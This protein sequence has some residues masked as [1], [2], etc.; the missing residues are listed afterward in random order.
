MI[1]NN[2]PQTP[3]D[4]FSYDHSADH[5]SLFFPENTGNTLDKVTHLETASP[6]TLPGRVLSHHPKAGLNPLVD[7]AGYLFS[8]LGKL[9]TLN[10]FCQLD[11][12]QTRLLQEL[13]IFQLTAKKHGYKPD[14][15]LACR[16][17]LSATFDDIVTHSGWGGQGQW[18]KYRLQNVLYPNLD[19]PNR[20]FAIIEYA[21]KEPALHIGL[22]ELAYLC[23]GMG[24]KGSY[25]KTEHNQYQL[26]LITNNLYKHIRAFRGNFG[27]LL[28]PALPKSFNRPEQAGKQSKLSLFYIFF[29]TI[30]INTIIFVSLGYLMDIISN[31]AYKN[32]SP[33]ETP[34]FEQASG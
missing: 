10:R 24:Y 7:A 26:E 12:L 18:D 16:Y 5:F 33:V 9:K 19:D 21:I 2:D 15:I 20:F 23:L 28:S 32:I 13:T 30:C 22:M 17:L 29:V 1:A 11:N 31:E 34:T 27:R 8:I 4:V 14:M 25:R 3:L 6:L